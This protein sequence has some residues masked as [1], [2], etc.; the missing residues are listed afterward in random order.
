MDTLLQDVR[1]SIRRLAKSPLFALIVIVTLALGIGANTA[2]FSA[3]N[4]ILLRP[5][6]YPEPQQ[7]LTINH[8]YPRLNNLKAPVSAIGFRD[9]QERTRSYAS[10]AV[11]ANWNANL[12]GV[13]EPVRLQGTKVTGRYF[14]T[15]GV[16]ALYGRAIQPGEDTLGHDHIVV[17]SH[18]LWQRLF[19]GDRSVIGRTLSLNGESYEVVGIMPAGFQDFFSRNAEIWAP[20]SFTPEQLSAGRTNEYLNLIA[21]LK[22]GVPVEQASSELRALSDQLKQ[23]YPGEYAPTWLL[24]AQPLSQLATGDI[25]P[26]LLVLLGAVGFVLLIACA[27]VANLLLARAAGR[28]REVAVRTALGATRERLVRQLL[29]ESVILAL[30]GGILGLA[31]AWVGLRTLVALKGGNLPRADE[32]GI[33]GSVMVYTLLISLLTGLLFGLAPALHFSAENMHENLKEG[34]RGATSDRG[35]HT[36]RRALVVAELALALTLLTGAGLLVKSFARLENVDPGF[37][38]DHLL[39]FGVA[40]PTTRYRSDTAQIAFFD[41]VLPRIAQIP[42][43]KAAGAT[44]VLPFSG[45]WTTGSFEVEGYQT[46]RDVPGPWGDIRIVS[47]GFFE[48]L[49]VPLI[50]GRVLTESDL[51]SSPLVT[52][53]DEEMVRRYWPNDNP[54]GKRITFGPAPGAAD[55]SSR[56]WIEV[57]G[58]VG[59]TKH[60]GLAAEPRVQCYFP[61]RQS[62]VPAMMV[63]TRTA[64]DPE[65]YVN[66]VRQAVRSVDPDQPISRVKTMETLLEQSVGQRKLSMLLLSLF[67]GIALLLASVGIYGVMSYSVAQRAREIGVRIALG[68]ERRDVLRMVLRQGMRLALT[69]VGVGLVTAFALTRVITS[70][71][72]EVRAT[73]PVTFVSVASLL[74]AVALVANLVPALR[75]TRVDPAVVLREE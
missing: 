39:T 10:M 18:G 47:P 42:G 50:K 49:R 51:A 66:A 60:E 71:L 70:Q 8:F 75:A 25:R 29:T 57:V 36:V 33:D 56:Q 45:S 6:P 22:P 74:I 55:T 7:L 5:L 38:P 1:Y 64:G 54:I 17:L 73:D 9:Y 2:I 53:V 46:P 43:I 21:R 23:E 16:P 19:G 37:D 67:S 3:V 68:A 13:G 63:A 4:A 28:T 12:T 30:G 32:I 34:S 35:S 48:A 40:L 58:V 59:H 11:E 31:L 69:G 72:Y 15:M 14:S 65:S 27:N 24:T 20:L 62:G 52:V 61:Y 44:S 26:A 41:A